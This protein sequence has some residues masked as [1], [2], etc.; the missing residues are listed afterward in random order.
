MK[1]LVG[2]VTAIATILF[3]LTAHPSLGAASY[4]IRGD[5]V[6]S[7]FDRG[8]TFK[9]AIPFFMLVSGEQ[10]Q[11]TT[12]PSNSVVTCDGTNIFYLDKSKLV[13]LPGRPPQPTNCYFVS[14][15]AGPVPSGGLSG[16]NHVRI[17]WFVYASSRVAATAPDDLPALWFNAR[18]SIEAH[19]YASKVKASEKS[20]YLPESASFTLTEDRFN[21]A[22]LSPWLIHEGWPHE[23]QRPKQIGPFGFE[24][25]TYRVMAVT[26]VNGLSLPV[27]FEL[28]LNSPSMQAVES[29]YGTNIVISEVPARKIEPIASDKLLRVVDFRFQNSERHI[30]F[31]QYVT[32]KW[33]V[34]TESPDL[35][36]LF[37]NKLT[38]PR[39]G[40]QLLVAPELNN[41]VRWLR[42]CILFVFLSPI[43]FTFGYRMYKRQLAKVNSKPL[44]NP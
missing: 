19:V 14:V 36:L 24:T 39:I 23:Y 12:A 13:T 6:H 3:Q 37:Q 34:S 8:G 9:Q 15:E 41:N 2:P 5:L 21:R 16:G 29:Y 26:N 33:I 4:E 1:K 32:K 31:I 35:Q 7:G 38:N 30:D 42:L 10:W 25:A 28:L 40:T 17:A 43:F 27:S 20:P 44:F 22:M 18:Y 11:I